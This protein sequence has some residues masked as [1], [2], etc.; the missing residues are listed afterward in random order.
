MTSYIYLNDRLNMWEAL[1]EYTILT[2]LQKLE[3][4]T[5][6][7]AKLSYEQRKNLPAS[8]FCGPGRSYPAHDAAHVRN[9]LARL[10]TFGSKLSPKI[11][12]RILSCL[13]SRAKKFGIEVSESEEKMILD[14]TR[15][16]VQWTD[17]QWIDWLDKTECK[18]CNV[19]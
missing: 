7:E 10:G 15:E 8:A 18:D 19:K 14:E 5:V 17:D 4:Y 13:R 16:T 1:I 3:G 2:Q 12:G 6:E 9:G 11:R